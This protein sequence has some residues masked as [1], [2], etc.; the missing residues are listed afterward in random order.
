MSLEKINVVTVIIS[1]VSSVIVSYLTIK[2]ESSSERKKR[3]NNAKYEILQKI[4]SRVQNGELISPI[5]IN[6]LRYNSFLG[7]KKINEL[8]DM[9]ES[10]NLYLLEYL[11]ILK[12]NLIDMYMREDT[13]DEDEIELNDSNDESFIKKI[14]DPYL[15]HH[16]DNEE[17]KYLNKMAFYLSHSNY[18][19]WLETDL[20]TLN[21]FKRRVALRCSDCFELYGIDIMMRGFENPIKIKDEK[22]DSLFMDIY[23]LEEGHLAKKEFDIISKKILLIVNNDIKML[24]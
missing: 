20:E 22:T 21:F 24:L 14:N 12:A 7:D 3:R 17:N 13:I 5:I 16:F 10:Y 11:H 9:L 18:I 15:E 6:E 2:F 1:I 8:E 19:Q 23:M 4:K